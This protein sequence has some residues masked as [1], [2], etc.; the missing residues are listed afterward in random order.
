MGLLV[1]GQYVRIVGVNFF[2]KPEGV[3]EARIQLS[4]TPS[5]SKIPLYILLPLTQMSDRSSL[6]PQAK[7]LLQSNG[8]TV[9]DS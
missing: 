2:F 9:E 3:I 4:S 8:F 7:T 5:G 1:N 6:Y